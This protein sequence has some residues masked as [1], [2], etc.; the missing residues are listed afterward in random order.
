MPAADISPPRIVA[1][2]RRFSCGLWR[3][4]RGD[5][6]NAYSG[7]RMPKVRVFVHEGRLFTN[8]GCLYSRGFGSVVNGHPLI[9][10]D[11]YRGPDSIPYSHEGREAIYQRKQ[12]RLGAKTVF[13]SSDPTVE[14]W[15]RLLRAIFADGGM[16][17]SGCTYPM[18]LTERC[19]PESSN[20]EAATRLELADCESGRIPRAKDEMRQWLDTG[21]RIIARQ[22]NLEL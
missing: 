19:P 7:D 1:H 21:K 3:V 15:R 2:W 22:L 14:E 17:A 10:A 9:P 6:D 12:F 13:V 20:N 5:I 11:E 16:F 4:P 8:T 18:F